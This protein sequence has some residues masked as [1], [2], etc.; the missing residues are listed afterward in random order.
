[1]KGSSRPVPAVLSNITGA[2]TYAASE[3]YGLSVR[4]SSMTGYDVFGPL[5]GAVSVF[6][7]IQG[8][9]RIPAG[10]TILQANGVSAYVRTDDDQPTTG[11]CFFGMAIATANNGKIFGLN[12][13]LTDSADGTVGTLTG[14][15]M[16]N[17][18]DFNVCCPGTSITGISF[19]GGSVSTPTSSTVIDIAFLNQ[20][21]TIVWNQGFTSR[22]GACTNFMVVGATH[23]SGNDRG[24]QPCIYNSSTA[25]GVA[26]IH[27][28]QAKPGAGFNG[29]F[30]LQTTHAA[31]YFSVELSTDYIR[32]GC[33]GSV[34]LV[35]ST[36]EM[37]FQCLA[38]AYNFRN[39]N[40]AQTLSV[41][42]STSNGYH[43]DLSCVT[44]NGNCTVIPA[45]GQLA[46]AAAA[47]NV[48]ATVGFMCVATCAGI[49]TGT[50]ANIPTGQ[51]PVVV[52]SVSG[53]P[54]LYN[55]SAWYA[56]PRVLDV[57]VAAVGNVGTGTDDLITYTIP[58]NVLSRNGKWIRISASGTTANNANAKTLTFVVGSQTVLSQA[59]TTSIAGQWEI[60][61]DIVR[62]GSNTQDI[63]ARVLQ[64]ATLIFTQTFT[65]G[66]Q[67]DT[68][69]ITVKCTG[70]ATS[71]NDIV[72]EMM[73]T[74]LKN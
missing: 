32:M 28:V 11:V 69:T 74:E 3:R 24:S 71:N 60:Q 70:N 6:D 63:R 34:C 66:T 33:D 49:P 4:N 18:F 38:N 14:V 41:W 22:N 16:E 2:M 61:V 31:N 37:R 7:A 10:S 36:D 23:A 51:Y 57:N 35:E 64:G 45:G 39:G 52:D 26:K 54:N 50:P 15:A 9:V 47:L 68:A 48:A 42:G 53:Q 29:W 19:H 21:E 59:L 44:A 65:A 8:V 20:A 58:A 40:N 43:L 67:T 12:P 17:E 25:A 27:Y 55:G 56:Q 73:Q 46:F 1:M 62:T 30:A 72:Q 5:F 13:V